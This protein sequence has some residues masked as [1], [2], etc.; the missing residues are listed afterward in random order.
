M[1]LTVDGGELSNEPDALFEAADVVH[2]ACGG[3]AG[4]VASMERAIDQ[5]SRFGTRVGAHPSYVDREG[6]GRRE[7]DASPTE[8][9][10]SIET[11]CRTLA[12]V[13]RQSG[14]VV[15]SAKP[16]GALYHA[17]HARAEIA[18]ACVRGIARALGSVAIVGLAGG[19][20]ERAAR[21]GGHSF[22]REAFADR[23]LRPDGT[24]VPRTEPGAVIDDPI[25][26]AA[27]T[28]RL[29]ASGSADVL[30]VHADTPSAVAI[31]RAVRDALDAP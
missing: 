17:A 16:H 2:I 5:C 14:A 11:Q 13:A 29:L 19:E 30:C 18:Q 15:T 21:E 22:L 4:D 7:R 20:L 3:H 27:T 31:A 10:A 1:L 8:L 24:L 25:A 23:A 28:R 9:E 6:F 12:G 26:A